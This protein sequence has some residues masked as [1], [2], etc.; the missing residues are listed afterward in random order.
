MA[1]REGVLSPAPPLI[2]SSIAATLGRFHRGSVRRGQFQRD[3]VDSIASG[4]RLMI[5]PTK[6]VHHFLVHGRIEDA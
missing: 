6:L 2:P 1:F 3:E 5:A 4:G